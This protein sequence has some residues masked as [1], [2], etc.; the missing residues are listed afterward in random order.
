MLHILMQPD[1]FNRQTD[2]QQRRYL[3]RH[4]VFKV[5]TYTDLYVLHEPVVKDALYR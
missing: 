4:N 1:I 5:R 3:Y 2:A